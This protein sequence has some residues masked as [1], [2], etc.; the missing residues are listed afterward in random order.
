MMHFTQEGKKRIEKEINTK[1][2]I[3]QNTK[4]FVDMTTDKTGNKGRT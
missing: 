4:R 3:V 2:Y 1:K